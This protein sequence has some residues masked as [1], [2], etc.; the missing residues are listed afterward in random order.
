MKEN[1]KSFPSA[2]G[3]IH[4]PGIADG[5]KISQK[6]AQMALLIEFRMNTTVQR[7]TLCLSVCKGKLQD[8]SCNMFC[9]YFCEV[10]HML[11]Q[12]RSNEECFSGIKKVQPVV[13]SFSQ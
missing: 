11:F 3:G 9:V 7:M 5:E 2:E 6:K 4:L 13:L 12:E 8:S 1:K 10:G